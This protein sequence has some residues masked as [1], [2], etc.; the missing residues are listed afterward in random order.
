MGYNKYL[1]NTGKKESEETFGQVKISPI[2][3]AAMPTFEVVIHYG[4]GHKCEIADYIDTVPELYT[5]KQSDI[6]QVAYENIDAGFP[7]QDH[8]LRQIGIPYWDI[9]QVTTENGQWFVELSK[10]KESTF[11]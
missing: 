10:D 11:K 3:E 2:D 1:W 5:R 9:L 6:N 7:Y 4:A 8:T